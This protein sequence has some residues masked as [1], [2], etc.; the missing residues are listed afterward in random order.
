MKPKMRVAISHTIFLRTFLLRAALTELDSGSSSEAKS[1]NEKRKKN[2]S[3]K[4]A[5]CRAPDLRLL[6]AAKLLAVSERAAERKCRSVASRN[7]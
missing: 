5:A 4:T 3:G 1:K 7:S 6:S 2:K